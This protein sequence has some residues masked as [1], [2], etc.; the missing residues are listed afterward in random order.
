[1]NSFNADIVLIVATIL[2]CIGARRCADTKEYYFY[3][4]LHRSDVECSGFGIC[5]GRGQMATAGRTGYV[6]VYTG[7]GG[8]R[9]FRWIGIGASGLSPTQNFGCRKAETIEG[10]S[11]P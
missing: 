4:D 9:G 3:I 7:D 1:M 11:N 5:G 10:C 2:F 6:P 8:C